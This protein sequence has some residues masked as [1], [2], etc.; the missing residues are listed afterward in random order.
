[1][2]D[3]NS[4]NMELEIWADSFKEGE[5]ILER[6][7][8]IFKGSKISYIH[9]FVPT[10]SIVSNKQTI[11][12]IVYGYYSSWKNIP[13]KISTL[14]DFGKPDGIIYDPKT[15]KI[16]LSYEET[17]AVPT[18]NQSQQ[19]LERVW[20]A[21]REKIPFVYLLGKYGMHKDG[22]IRTTSIWPSYLAL[23]LTSQYEVP[24][25]T[26]LYGSKTEPENYSIGNSI[27]HLESL[28]K[29]FLEK[30]LNQDP[31]ELEL[32]TLLKKIYHEM[33]KFIT[34]QYEEIS[35]KLP[36]SNLLTELSLHAYLTKKCMMSSIQ[37]EY[38]DDFK[39]PLAFKHETYDK[40]SF[41]EFVKEIELLVEQKKAWHP[42]RGST[43]RTE[44][45]TKIKSWSI[46]QTKHK[47]DVEKKSKII[48]ETK[49]HVDD[50]PDHNS[51]KA[52]STT[53]KILTLI[54]STEDFLNSFEKVFGKK[55]RKQVEPLL[56]IHIPTVLYVSSSI[57]ANGRAFKGDPFTG[58]LTAF[59]RIFS[60]G[61]NAEKE[62][63]MITYYPNQL[64]SQFFNKKYQKLDN[65]GV[66]SI[67]SNVDLIITRDGL[68]ID[69]KTWSLL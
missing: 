40:K 52:I 42:M 61:F 18:G 35:D 48:K 54:D 51:K 28:I 19:R 37:L 16:I 30:H 27:S 22:G 26:L 31:K 17:S 65:K 60:I 29:W 33:C 55:I 4:N 10:L 41:D 8:H 11:N 3:S 36:G 14:L 56:N 21:A 58:Q 34:D 20:Y 44:E 45:I 62:R 47:N 50:F 13:S 6:I 67:E 39:W 15:D 59:S 63:N 46:T 38:T 69:P 24:S 12:F 25:L 5:F 2:V 9:G 53:K 68:T 7:Q 23:N 66:K 32:E 49:I 43:I 57:H 1:M 64:Y